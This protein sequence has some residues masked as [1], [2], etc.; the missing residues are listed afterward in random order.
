[1]ADSA[2][3]PK[4]EDVLSSVRRLVSQELPKREVSKPVVPDAGAL[5]L[6]SKDRIEADP[7]ARHETRSLEERIAELEAAVDNS[8][9][10]FEPDGSEDQ[11]Q[12]RPDRIVF[13][14]PRPSD[15][16]RRRRTTLRLSEIALIETGPA[17]EV[18]T[19]KE[20]QVAFRHEP[21]RPREKQD[22]QK[23]AGADEAPM[24]EDVPTLPAS[25]AELHAFSDDPDDVVARIEARIEQ[26]G[27][28]P[29]S[30]PIEAPAAKATNDPED[31]ARFTAA[32]SAAVA[33]S[34]LVG[35]S[36]ESSDN[37]TGDTLRP[38]DAAAPVAAEEK[39]NAAELSVSGPAGATRRAQLVRDAAVS[40]S[41]IAAEPSTEAKPQLEVA[42]AGETPPEAE[43][44]PVGQKGG[45]ASDSATATAAAALDELPTEE[46]LRLLVARLMRE[47]L[48]GKLGE[49]MTQNIRK[50]VRREVKRVLEARNLD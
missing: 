48:Q 50:L 11:S 36:D 39:T 49:R 14:R 4:V 13:T 37:E 31:D 17:V 43:Q 27:E 22:V 9:S 32:L 6:T 1:M 30:L 21:A 38:E 47:E 45:S 26:G 25:T 5:V 35:E 18:E 20:P 15:E 29:Q 40:P 33:A 8:S 46:A 34:Q 7:K 24:A 3:D 19:E 10:E 44:E 23:S 41:I 2:P 12:H 42:Q 16:V 28:A